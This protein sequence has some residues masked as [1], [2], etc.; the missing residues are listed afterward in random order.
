[1]SNRIFRLSLTLVLLLFFTAGCA[2]TYPCQANNRILSSVGYTHGTNHS[3]HGQ[4]QEL[5]SP[6]PR[7]TAA[8]C[9][10]VRYSSAVNE[11]MS[12]KDLVLAALKDNPDLEEAFAGV[13]ILLERDQKD[14]VVLVCSPDGHDA[15]LEDA[16]WTAAHVDREWYPSNPPKPAEFTIKLRGSGEP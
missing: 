6:L 1:M 2:T 11:R 16:S 14:V 3:F 13:P 9:A 5:V 4:P 10:V 8:I 15:W 7:L 12:D